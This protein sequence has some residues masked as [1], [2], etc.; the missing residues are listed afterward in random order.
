M[1]EKPQF[2]LILKSLKDS[3]ERIVLCTVS[4]EANAQAMR[5][6]WRRLLG[7]RQWTVD[8]RPGLDTLDHLALTV[9]RVGSGGSV[10]CPHCH[11]GFAPSVIEQHIREKHPEQVS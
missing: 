3:S 2:Q 6:Q 9:V 10:E 11:W 8:R 5:K 4:S 1:S 7:N